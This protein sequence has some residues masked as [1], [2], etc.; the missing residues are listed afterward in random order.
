MEE[1]KEGKWERGKRG[2]EGKRERGRE[3]REGSIRPRSK[4]F[5]ALSRALFPLS[6]FSPCK[7][8]YTFASVLNKYL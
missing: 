5:P 3:E 1:G 7:M 4:L 6:P 8:I 2:K